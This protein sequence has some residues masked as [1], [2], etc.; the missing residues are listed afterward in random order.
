MDAGKQVSRMSNGMLVHV[1]KLHDE[2][3]YERGNEEW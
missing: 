1:L 2:I 3:N